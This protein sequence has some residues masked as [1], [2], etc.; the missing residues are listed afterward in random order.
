MDFERQLGQHVVDELDRG[1]LVAALVDPQ[2][3]QSGAVVDR[4]ELVVLLAGA[5]ERCDELD[6]HLEPWPGCCFS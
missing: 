3:T 5:G 1:R 4:G 2:H 6:V